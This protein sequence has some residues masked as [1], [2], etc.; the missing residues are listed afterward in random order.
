[1]AHTQGTGPRHLLTRSVEGKTEARQ[2]APGFELDKMN[3]EVANYKKFLTRVEQI[4]EV[5]EAICE[6]RP[7]LALIDQVPLD[8]LGP[9]TG[10]SSVS[11]RRPSRPR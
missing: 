7:V 11:S 1:M 10:G 8:G 4:V 5:N 2:V 6:D 9:E 3:R